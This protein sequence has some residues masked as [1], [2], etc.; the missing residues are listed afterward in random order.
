MSDDSVIRL[1]Q[2][3]YLDDSVF[4][5]NKMCKGHY[6]GPDNKKCCCP[7]GRC[8]YREQMDRRTKGQKAI[9]PEAW[10]GLKD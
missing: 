8:W 7:Q 6:I 1:D 5:S 2:S 4:L 10:D 3:S 9:R